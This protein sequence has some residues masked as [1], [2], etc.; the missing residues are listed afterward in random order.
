MTTRIPA[1]VIIAIACCARLALADDAAKAAEHVAAAKK[2]FAAGKYADAIGEF[3]A[4]NTLAPDPKIVYAIAQAQRMAGDCAA[5]IVSYDEFIQASTDKKLV[6]FSKANIARC[7]EQL[8]KDK[9]ARPSDPVMTAPPENPSEPVEPGVDVREPP[10]MIAPPP[11]PVEPATPVAKPV[12][13][14][15][16]LPPE[17]RPWTRDWLGHAL[18][19]GG[20][21][22][23]VAG[24]IVWLG[25]RADAQALN[26]AK[27]N[28]TFLGKRGAASSALTKQRVGIAMGLGGVA[29]VAGGILHYKLGGKHE[30][31]VAIAPATGG[32]T[33][34]IGGEL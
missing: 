30:A 23:G 9:K 2:A 26:D 14:K 29:L 22:V 24:T 1:L 15:V 16:P 4:A 8:A 31:H 34:V 21:G 3:R 28:Q 19:A 10:K 18:V 25:G 33:L 6:E 17:S 7:K 27:D 20:V 12:E 32:G 13:S 5:A 11:K